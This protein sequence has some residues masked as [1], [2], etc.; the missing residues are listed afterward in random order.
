MTA[1]ANTKRRDAILREM[2]LAPLWKLRNPVLPDDR[3][4][5]PVSAGMMPA[6]GEMVSV[7]NTFPSTTDA[8]AAAI[9]A[10]DWR[11]LRASVADCRACALCQERK[12]AVLGAG[13]ETAD[14]LFVG[15][16]PGADEDARGEPFIGQAG[17]LLDA[18]LVSIG[19]R[20]G[21][22]VYIANAVKCR[23]PGNRTPQP[24]E[25]AACRP[26]LE[27]QIALLQP[28]LIV[29]LGRPAAQTLLQDEVN[30]SA[31]RGRLLRTFDDV[32]L[33]VSYHP[34]YLIR[35]PGEKAKAWED[36]C[37]ARRTMQMKGAGDQ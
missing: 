12:Q 25:M 22:N 35:K 2:G 31:M 26:Y 16:A 9:A 20:R 21:Q 11:E 5:S 4:A 14:W 37:L 7:Q 34:A 24:E 32:P 33:M 8:R 29:A 19:L 36:L 13:D 30:I 18:M 1:P 27:R 3:D 23:P 28:R 15:E 17:K 6:D 10:M